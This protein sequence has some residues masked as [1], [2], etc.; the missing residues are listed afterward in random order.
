MIKPEKRSAAA[1]DARRVPE[2]QE[3]STLGL[4]F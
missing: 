1:L 2:S 4:E 3:V